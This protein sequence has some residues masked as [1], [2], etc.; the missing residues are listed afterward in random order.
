MSIT[1][2][3]NT[4]WYKVA[5]GGHST[6]AATLPSPQPH[7]VLPVILLL[8]ATLVLAMTTA[9]DADPK[10][11]APRE[12]VVP[13]LPGGAGAVGEPKRITTAA[14]LEKAV[15]DANARAAI[16]KQADLSKEHLLLFSWSGSGQD[17][18]AVAPG[19]DGV[20]A[21]AFT[22]GRTK[23]RRQHARLFAIP[24][25]AKVSVAK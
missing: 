10:A 24:P 2:F 7:E 1:L 25:A 9:P 17:A 14:E 8:T 5:C 19:K 18:L 11:A 23:D 22:G 12:I 15:P 13:G 3:P 6:E 4:G 21:F 20:A 16:L